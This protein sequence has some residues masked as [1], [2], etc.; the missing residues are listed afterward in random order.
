VAAG[1]HTFVQFAGVQC[2]G[3]QGTGGVDPAVPAL[4]TVGQSL[5]V[6]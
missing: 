3:P 4:K 6:A 1:A 2:H 5:T